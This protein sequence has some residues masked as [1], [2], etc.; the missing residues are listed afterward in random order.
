MTPD[1][2]N[3]IV[4]T[5]NNLSTHLEYIATVLTRIMIAL[6]SIVV[7]KLIQDK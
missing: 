5:T 7:I 2:L 3:L 1:Q 6:W 4:D